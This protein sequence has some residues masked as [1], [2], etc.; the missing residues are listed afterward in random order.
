MISYKI[1]VFQELNKRGINSYT[2]S[3]NK[4]FSQGTMTKLKNGDATISFHVLDNLCQILELQPGDIIEYREEEK[5][6][7]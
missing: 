3:K 7:F 6:G 4:L 5:E 2:S 1:D